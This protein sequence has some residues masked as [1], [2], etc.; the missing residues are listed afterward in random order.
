VTFEQYDADGFDHMRIPGYEL[1]IP[2]DKEQLC[3]RLAKLFPG[4]AD[5]LRNFLAEVA[6]LLNDLD[7][8]INNVLKMMRRVIS[9]TAIPGKQSCPSKE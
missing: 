1:D 3:T 2:Y 5:L 6:M 8:R 7:Q 9:A 4:H